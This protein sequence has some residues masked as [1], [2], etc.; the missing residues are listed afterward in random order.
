MHGPVTPAQ[1]EHV[2]QVKQDD[3]KDRNSEEVGEDAFHGGL[4][5]LQE[6]TPEGG[7]WFRWG[8]RVGECP[9]LHAAFKEFADQALIGDATSGG[10]GFER[11]Q[12]GFGKAHVDAGGFGG[13]FPGEGAELGGVEGGE[14]LGEEVSG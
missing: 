14:V 3:D 8:G 4:L 6:I 7:V 11:G 9:D 5:W 10:F 13:G 12:Q 1:S 2:E